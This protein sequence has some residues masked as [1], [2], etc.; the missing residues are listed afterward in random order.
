MTMLEKLL[1]TVCKC[2]FLQFR[3]KKVRC[4][5]IWIT[6][7]MGWEQKICAHANKFQMAKL[8]FVT[9]RPFFTF[10]SFMWWMLKCLSLSRFC[11][12]V[13]VSLIEY[14]I[15]QP[16]FSV[17]RNIRIDQYLVSLMERITFNFMRKITFKRKYDD[18]I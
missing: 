13:F 1:T 4:R 14:M 2:N 3:M 10:Q 18:V 17:W 16:E 15:P 7:F 6:C 5:C 8:V 12:F 11:Y 9:I